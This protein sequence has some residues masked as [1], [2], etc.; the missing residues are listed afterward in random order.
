MILALL[1]SPGAR[2]Q[3]ACIEPT[4]PPPID[5]A[6]ATMA[7]MQAATATVKKYLA[8]SDAF[9]NCLVNEIAAIDVDHE[10]AKAKALQKQLEPRTNANQARKEHAGDTINAA[11]KAYKAAHPG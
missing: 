2:A 11:I 7:Q 10:P 1:A 4:E 3:S 9:Q 6:T 5:G 8:D